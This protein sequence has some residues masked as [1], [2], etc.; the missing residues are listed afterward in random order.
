MRNRAWSLLIEASCIQRVRT[1][2]HVYNQIELHVT[3]HNVPLCVHVLER[4]AGI[5]LAEA[6][7]PG[8]AAEMDEIGKIAPSR[9][10][11]PVLQKKRSCPTQ[12]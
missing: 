9:S 2:C 10:W 11:Q 5:P 8:Y 1:R 7:D 3:T 4:A 6:R 12:F